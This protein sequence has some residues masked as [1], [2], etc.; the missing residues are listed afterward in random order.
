MILRRREP[1]LCE[2]AVDGHRDRDPEGESRVEQADR[3]GAADAG[4][5]ERADAEQRRRQKRAA[6]VV[7]AEDAAV[8]LRGLAP[9]D[10]RCGDRVRGERPGPGGELGPPRR[11]PPPREQAGQAQREQGGAESDERVHRP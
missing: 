10:R 8:P 3:R 9:G 2:G 7:D 4:E 1:V 6:R 5:Q 11:P